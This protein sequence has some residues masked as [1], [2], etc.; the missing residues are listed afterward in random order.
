MEGVEG[1]AVAGEEGEMQQQRGA[2]LPPVRGLRNALRMTLKDGE[3]Q[4]PARHS[5]RNL[6]WKAGPRILLMAPF[7]PPFDP[8][9]SVAPVV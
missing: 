6:V 1:G 5:T 2:M 4:I 8:V 3:V 9:A 7:S